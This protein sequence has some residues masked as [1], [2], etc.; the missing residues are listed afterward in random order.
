MVNIDPELQES[1]AELRGLMAIL[2]MTTSSPFRVFKKVAAR[3]S[4]RHH[5]ARHDY[6]CLPH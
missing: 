1:S 5:N 3:V 2:T 4:Q 6:F